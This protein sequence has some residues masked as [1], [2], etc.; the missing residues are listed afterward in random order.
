MKYF[1][2][3]RFILFYIFIFLVKQSYQNEQKQLERF[4]NSINLLISQTKGIINNNSLIFEYDKHN[5]TLKNFVILKPFNNNSTIKKEKN[6]NNEIFLNVNYLTVLIKA[7]IIIQLLVRKEEPIYNNS[8]FFELYFKEI[9]FKLINNFN[10]DFYSS[11]IES[12]IYNNLDNLEIFKEF[13]DKKL[14]IFYEEEKEPIFLEDYDSKLKEVFRIKFEEK[15]KDRQKYFNLLTYDMINLF[16]NYPYKF[17]SN[18]FNY[19][20]ELY[21]KKFKVG[22]ND[23]KLNLENNSISMNYFTLKGIYLFEGFSDLYFD[24]NITC[25]KDVEHFIFQ[26]NNNETYIAFS[27][28]DCNISDNNFDIFDNVQDEEI[29]DIIQN[30]YANYIKNITSIYYNDIFGES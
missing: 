4:K 15:I 26:R 20:M 23:I 2:Q 8:I 14:C 12:L 21:L 5:I 27:I 10:I 30:Y 9:K 6:E 1:N 17:I 28:K 25:Y 16:D 11:K 19:I 3:K 22:E 29:R 7:D 18:N 13:N 24:F